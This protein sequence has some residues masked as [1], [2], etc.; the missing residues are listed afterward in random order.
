MVITL[1]MIEEKR[2]MHLFESFKE[3]NVTEKSSIYVIPPQFRKQNS[4]SSL[5]IINE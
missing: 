5:Q 4:D 1:Q 3:E 2:E